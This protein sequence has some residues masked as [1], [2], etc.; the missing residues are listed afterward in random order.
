MLRETT[1]CTV[2]SS[3][4]FSRH[5]LLL[6]KILK[7]KWKWQKVEYVHVYHSLCLDFILTLFISSLPITLPRICSRVSLS[8]SRLYPYSL[9]IIAPYHTSS[10][11]LV[12]PSGSPSHFLTLYGSPSRFFTLS[13]LSL[14]L[15]I[16]F[17][18]SLQ[19]PIT[20]P[21]SLW[22]PN[23]KHHPF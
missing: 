2:A 4:S 9:Q 18:H 22:L 19:L 5:F 3:L 8:L 10:L 13:G 16:M 1:T 17:P 11:S 20:L 7:K 23:T 14:R 6:K 12:S 15:P 21:H